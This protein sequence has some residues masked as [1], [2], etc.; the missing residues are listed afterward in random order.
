MD[1]CRHVSGDSFV[2]KIVSVHTPEYISEIVSVYKTEFCKKD[3]VG[4]NSTIL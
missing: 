3:K 1:K 4:V 2:N